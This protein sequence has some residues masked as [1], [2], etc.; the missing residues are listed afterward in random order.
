MKWI[1]R[2]LRIVSTNDTRNHRTSQ[3]FLE[4]IAQ[5][6]E[7]AWAFNCRG[8][9]TLRHLMERYP[10][11]R[12]L[13]AQLRQRS[14]FPFFFPAFPCMVHKK[15][16]VAEGAGSLLAPFSLRSPTLPRGGMLQITVDN[17]SRQ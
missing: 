7:R 2:R 13:Y 14:D 4:E 6:A 15:C 3:I 12:R 16:T 9:Q 11:G 10:V 8:E 5:R 1:K 17:P